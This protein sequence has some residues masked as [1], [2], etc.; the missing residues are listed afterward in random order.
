MAPAFDS[1]SDFEKVC[2]DVS[3]SDRGSNERSVSTYVDTLVQ[4]RS[5]L[6]GKGCVRAIMRVMMTLTH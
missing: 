5:S 1:L 6:V 2:E 4:I 3:V